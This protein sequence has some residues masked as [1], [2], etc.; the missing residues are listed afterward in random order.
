MVECMDRG[1]A[2]WK[3]MMSDNLLNLELPIW[4]IKAIIWKIEEASL[5]MLFSISDLKE[6][7][8]RKMLEREVQNGFV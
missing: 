7:M 6:Y 3:L 2:A 1:A 8:Q 4:K 5:R